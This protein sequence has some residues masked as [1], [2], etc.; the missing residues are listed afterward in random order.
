RVAAF[1]SSLFWIGANDRASERGW[2]W[3]D[4]TPFAFLN[5]DDMQPDNS[6]DSDCSVM[7]QKTGKWD[8][9]PCQSRNAYIC[10][11]K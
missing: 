11:R 2:R 8:D 5:W 1:P 7:S 10:K 4:G 3:S 9:V 6:G